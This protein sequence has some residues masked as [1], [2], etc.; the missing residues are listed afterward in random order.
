MIKGLPRWIID[1]APS[2]AASVRCKQTSGSKDNL[3]NKIGSSADRLLL[4]FI[5]QLAYL[6]D[7]AFGTKKLRLE[8][9]EEIVQL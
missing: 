4:D 8:S 3:Q 7:V 1:Q 2:H 6:Q 5:S 9:G